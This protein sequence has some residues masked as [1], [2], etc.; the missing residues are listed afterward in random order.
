MQAIST[1]RSI[2]SVSTGRQCGTVSI[3]HAKLSPAAPRRN[4]L[5]FL[6]AEANN[7]GESITN[8]GQTKGKDSYEVLAVQ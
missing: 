6:R 8:S 7:T 2:A 3:L 4:R 5:T 1:H